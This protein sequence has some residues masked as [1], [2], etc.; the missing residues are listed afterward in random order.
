MPRPKVP[1][2]SRRKTLES[3][4]RIID[5]EGLEALNIRR[6]ARELNVNGASLYHHFEN[7]GAILTEVAEYALASVRPPETHDEPWQVWHLR[8]MKEFRRAL[9]AHPNL[10]PIILDR[11]SLGMG[12]RQMDRTAALLEEEGMPVTLIHSLLRAGEVITIGSVLE[13]TRG[14]DATEIPDGWSTEF[15]HLY[16]AATAPS[17]ISSEVFFDAL[18]RA[19]IELFDAEAAAAAA[20]ANAKAAKKRSKATAR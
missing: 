11:Q 17:P 20:K 7:K 2:I 5:E 19:V 4:L 3:A 8:N 16:R 1:L 12:A 6:L 9:L 15:P 14:D 10:I 18:S 13:E